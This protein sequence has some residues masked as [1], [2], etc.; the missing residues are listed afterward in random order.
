M[1]NPE[2]SVQTA[3]DLAHSAAT[4]DRRKERLLLMVLAAIQF[5]NILDFVIIMPL[6]PQFMRVFGVGSQEFGLIV[7]SYTFS[8]GL[9]GLI[10]A[11]FIDRFDRR[12]SLLFL[13]TGFA[14]GTGMCAVAPNYILLIGARVLAG[15]FG[16][17]LASV[18]LSIVGDV[19]PYERR[20]AAM[21]VIMSS[22]SLATVIGVPIGLYIATKFGWHWTFTTLAGTSALILFVASRV[23]P[24]IHGHLA[25]TTVRNPL[26][27]LKVML[28]NKN[29]LRVYAFMVMLMLAGFTVFPFISPYLVYNVGLQEGELTY[30]YA[31]GGFC[32][33]FS[34]RFIG[35]VADRYG[36]QRVF[37]FL[38]YFSTVPIFLMTIL[39]P[40]P[41]AVVLL[42]SA[43]FFVLASGRGVP[44]FAMITASVEPKNRGSFMS[45]NTSVQHWSAGLG[46]FLAGLVIVSGSDRALNNFGFVGAFAVAATIACVVLSK[47]LVKVDEGH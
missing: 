47:R 14:I 43:V 29:Y 6:G 31:L 5:T 3:P 24:S 34:S 38:A 21:G 13:Y 33:F 1:S 10:G 44:A 18:I 39:P 46:S 42:F 27:T 9:F 45:F 25:H 36:K 41:L 20:G 35:R 15:V 19:I 40:L 11:F 12:T 2:R 28:Q 17:V 26:E 23:I 7:S 22:F 32:T 37:V 8:S 4:I 30:V 16:G